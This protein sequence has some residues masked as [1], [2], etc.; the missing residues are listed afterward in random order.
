M[1]KTFQQQQDENQQKLIVEDGEGI[2][3]K[4]VLA[5]HRM[6]GWQVVQLFV[7]YIHEW[8]IFQIP[9][10]AFKFTNSRKEKKSKSISL[11][12]FVIF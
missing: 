6:S 7:W 5:K 9:T 3:S 8:S 4:M 10:V 12:K 11:H 1:Y 2:A